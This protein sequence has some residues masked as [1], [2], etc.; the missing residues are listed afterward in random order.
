MQ[1]LFGVLYATPRHCQEFAADLADGAENWGANRAGPRARSIPWNSLARIGLETT[2][3]VVHLF[4]TQK[5]VSNTIF[6]EVVHSLSR[7]AR[8]VGLSTAPGEARVS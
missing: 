6:V 3:I 1:C 7:R 4:Y 8:T 2:E 5:D